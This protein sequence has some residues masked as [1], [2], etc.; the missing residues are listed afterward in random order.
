MGI[1]DILTIVDGA[2]SSNSIDFKAKSNGVYVE[3]ENEW[4]GDSETGFG[5][6]LGIHLNYDQVLQARNFLDN[7]LKTHNEK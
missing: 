2:D 3:I 7:W 5:Y 6:T 4:C 1:E